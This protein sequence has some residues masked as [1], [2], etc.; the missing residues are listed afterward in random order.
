MT[1]ELQ[2]RMATRED[3]V[4]VEEMSDAIHPTGAPFQLLEELGHPLSQLWLALSEERAVGYC[5][6]RTVLDETEVLHIE[7]AESWRKRGVGR[8]L[9]NHALDGSNNNIVL[10][11][12]REGNIPAIRLYESYGFH[13]VGRRKAY[14]REPIEDAIL[15]K[16]P[17]EQRQGEHV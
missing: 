2:V 4:S 8:T 16:R 11:E 9:L 1:V 3:G 5:L 15:M 10:L 13:A 14:Y 7:V 6:L 12:V 17:L